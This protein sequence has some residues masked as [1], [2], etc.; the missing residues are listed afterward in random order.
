MPFRRS[1]SLTGAM[2]FVALFGCVTPVFA[3]TTSTLDVDVKTATVIDSALHGV[4]VEE[5]RQIPS[6]LGLWWRGVREQAILLLT[7]DPVEKAEKQLQFAEERQR[8]AEFIVAHAANP[9]LQARAE[10]LMQGAENLFKK[11]E[12][13]KD[14]WVGVQ[15]ERVERLLNNIASHEIRRDR[16]FD[17][18]ENTL[19]PE[20]LERVQALRAESL[21]RGSRLLNAI[22]NEHIPA[23]I[24]E[25]LQMVKDRI[26]EHAMEVRAFSVERSALQT[27]V[28]EGDNEARAQLEDLRE[29]RRADIQERQDA[30][31]E[32]FATQLERAKEQLRAQAAAGNERAAEAL[33]R[34]EEIEARAAAPSEPAEP[35]EAVPEAVPEE[36]PVEPQQIPQPQPHPALLPVN[37]R[38]AVEAIRRA[39]Q[40]H[41]Q[42]GEEQQPSS[43][44]RNLPRPVAPRQEE[45][46]PPP[47]QPAEAPQPEPAHEEP[48]PLFQRVIIDSL[49]PHI[50]APPAP[51]PQPVAPI[52]PQID[53]IK[54]NPI[55]PVQPSP[56][57]V[58]VLTST[59]RLPRI[60]TPIRRVTSS[61]PILPLLNLKPIQ[62]IQLPRID[63]HF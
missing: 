33:R 19:S 13:K 38:G 15:S 17:D 26:E 36:Q 8:L 45:P 44:L 31:Q 16:V 30:R 22:N 47:E 55:L 57:P 37:T 28:R 29:E 7:F 42:G 50:E 56:I 18:L 11:L 21:A 5:P 35:V 14:S 58:P 60:I 59:P 4:K 24:R 10:S 23:D 61:V 1:I 48:A 62:P 63:I 25:H 52:L 54:L 46:Q 20:E 49:I 6:F 2:M 51:A 32:D 34:I 39:Q 40:H 12:E 41:D 3:Q 9:A 53:P 43:P 27:R